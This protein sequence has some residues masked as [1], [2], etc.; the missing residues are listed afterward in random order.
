VAEVL[1]LKGDMKNH[2]DNGLYVFFPQERA[3]AYISLRGKQIHQ[4]AFTAMS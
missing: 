1:K 2:A 3:K 4:T